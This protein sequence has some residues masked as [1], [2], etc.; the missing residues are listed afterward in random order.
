MYV[1]YNVCLN[2]FLT[3]F[4]AQE[5]LILAIEGKRAALVPHSAGNY[6]QFYDTNT[7]IV[8]ESGLKF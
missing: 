1:S 5:W 7:K 3:T 6:F 8:L 2:M 4:G